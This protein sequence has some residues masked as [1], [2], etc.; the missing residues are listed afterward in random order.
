MIKLFFLLDFS[1]TTQKP[2]EQRVNRSTQEEKKFFTSA[3]RRLRTES[4]S[5]ESQ[6]KQKVLENSRT[7]EHTTTLT[8]CDLERFAILNY[9]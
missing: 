7:L 8:Q 4:C 3:D 9:R 5:G 2:L 1:L 6:E